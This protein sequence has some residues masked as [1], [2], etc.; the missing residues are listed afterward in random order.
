MDRF[1]PNHRDLKGSD[2][3]NLVG[4]VE[5]ARR[6]AAFDFTVAQQDFRNPRR[7]ESR[8]DLR[9]QRL[10][11]RALA[12]RRLGDLNAMPIQHGGDLHAVA[13]A[14]RIEQGFISL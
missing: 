10:R 8:L 1:D 7:A 14:R 6:H 3:K 11:G 12:D 5:E 9:E 4:D 13:C 2:Q